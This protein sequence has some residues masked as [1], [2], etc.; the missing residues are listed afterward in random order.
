[1][2]EKSQATAPAKAPAPAAKAAPAVKA[3]APKVESK[4][5]ADTPG[6]TE[7]S[8]AAGPF[9]EPLAATQEAP[10]VSEP[11]LSSLDHDDLKALCASLNEQIIALHGEGKHE[12]GDK[13][14]SKH[15]NALAELKAKANPLGYA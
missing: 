8:F 11:A 15:L 14:R 4:P 5:P 2:N 6:L 12:E 3:E 13:L 10:A 9:Q 7:H 1:M